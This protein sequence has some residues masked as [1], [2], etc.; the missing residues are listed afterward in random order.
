[1]MKSNCFTLAEGFT[2]YNSLVGVVGIADEPTRII[3]TST[4]YL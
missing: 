2:D 4:K 3:A 1:M